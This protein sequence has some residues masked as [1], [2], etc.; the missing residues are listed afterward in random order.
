MV[1]MVAKEPLAALDYAE[2]LPDRLVIA[3]R[4]GSVRLIDNIHIELRG[5]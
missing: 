3:A 4:F 2:V 5:V 1:N